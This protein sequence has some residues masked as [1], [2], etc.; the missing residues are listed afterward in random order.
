M[1]TGKRHEIILSLL[2]DYGVVNLSE[3]VK[4]TESSESTIRRDLTCLEEKNLLKRVHGGAT[5]INSKIKELSDIEKVDKNRIE[6][7]LIAKYAATLV[8]DG[9]CIFLDA[10]T[11]TLNL[12]KHIKS[13]NVI[14]VTNGLTHINALISE[15]INAYMLGG[16]VKESTKAVIG[17]SA[18]EQLK[19]FRF[20]KCFMGSNG[21]HLK[22]GCTT[23]DPEEA[24]L[25]KQVIKLS[26]ESFVVAD[27]SKFG[28]VSFMKFANLDE[29]QLVT[30]YNE[31]NLQEYKDKTI[32]KVVE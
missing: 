27:Y 13:K 30:N 32:V 3:F 12:I 23:P 10:G 7:I 8:K 29:V 16:K 26:R 9:E 15:G 25:K 2:K 31:E 6:K 14:V 20:D 22:F 24:V 17:T 28:E 19:D 11:T 1:I 4:A 5:L 21:V 18:I